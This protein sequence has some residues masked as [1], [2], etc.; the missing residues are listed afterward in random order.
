MGRYEVVGQEKVLSAPLRAS[1]EVVLELQELV[2]AGLA[3]CTEYS[4]AHML[5]SDL[6]LT[7]DVVPD[8]CLQIIV[9]V[10]VGEDHVVPDA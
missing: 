5:R 4:A 3:H 10:P 9:P 8:Q 1:V 6:H 2:G 7:G